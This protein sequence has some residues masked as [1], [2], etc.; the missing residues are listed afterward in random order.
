MIYT[1]RTQRLIREALGDEAKPENFG[2]GLFAQV[3]LSVLVL[4][5]GILLSGW[6]LA[7]SDTANAQPQPLVINDGNWF[8]MAHA[9]AA[10]TRADNNVVDL[11]YPRSDESADT[12]DFA[13]LPPTAAGKSEQD[14]QVVDL[15]Y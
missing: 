14:T 13:T 1:A 6:K 12:D 8:S 5:I 2:E 3:I 4:I 15:T 10:K 11:T 7:G 9:Q